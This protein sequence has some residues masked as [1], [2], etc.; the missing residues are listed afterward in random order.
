MDIK[1]LSK[2][3]SNTRENQIK[4]IFANLFLVQNRLQTEFDNKMDVITLKQFMLLIMIKQSY[5]FKEEITLTKLGSLLGCSRQNVKK[6]ALQLEQKKFI[7]IIPSKVDSR[8][9]SIQPLNLLH[10][11]FKERNEENMKMLS[12]IFSKYTD[13]EIGKFYNLLDKLHEGVEEFEDYEKD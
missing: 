4:G 8:A 3:H 10:K 12:V 1:D 2:K 9:S 11:Y 5:E 7:K 6:L 13:K